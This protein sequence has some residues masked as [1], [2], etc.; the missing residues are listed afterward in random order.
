MSR[1][2]ESVAF[3]RD[4][5]PGE[6]KTRQRYQHLYGEV[7]GCILNWAQVI[8]QDIAGSS[9]WSTPAPAE[10]SRS[11]CHIT[12][13]RLNRTSSTCSL[14]VA[15]AIGWSQPHARFFRLLQRLRD[16]LE[17]R[18]APPNSYNGRHLAFN[19]VP[20]DIGVR[21]PAA[22]RRRCHRHRVGLFTIRQPQSGRA[23]K[24]PEHAMGPLQAQCLL[25]RPTSRP[26]GSMEQ[27]DVVQRQRL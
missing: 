18:P 2:W 27:S 17:R 20:R 8:A 23:S 14:P 9:R 22:P 24:Q 7:W 13:N 1:R 5:D 21:P 11:S 15:S 6:K 4:K 10:S 3:A 25:W 16:P 12:R 19:G 26:G